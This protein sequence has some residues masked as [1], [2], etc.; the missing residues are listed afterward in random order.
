MRSAFDRHVYYYIHFVI[1]SIINAV[2][3]LFL[4]NQIEE[5]TRDYKMNLISD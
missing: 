5:S 2:I 3:V 4:T 1:Y